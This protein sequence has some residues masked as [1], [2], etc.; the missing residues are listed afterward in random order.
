MPLD[1]RGKRIFTYEEALDSFP[2]VR[3]LT[4][5]AQRRID[6]L[7]SG[8]EEREEAEEKRSEVEA[9]V[10]RIVEVWANE[11]TALGCEVKGVWLV[12][13]D[14]GDGYYCWKFPEQT[15]SHFH[16]YEEGFAG[17]VPIN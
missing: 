11:I 1:R 10:Q 12:D 4:A 9:A 14:S 15:V 17:R 7:L 5:A 13:W 2:Q 3:D 16:G 6:A 8:A